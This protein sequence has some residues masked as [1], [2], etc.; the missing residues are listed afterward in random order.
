MGGR[1]AEELTQDDIASGAVQDIQTAT[2]LAR[3]MVCVWG[4]SDLGP[5]ALGHNEEPVFLGRDYVQRPNYSEATAV[6]IDEEVKRI[7]EVGLTKARTTLTDY[8][9]A[10]DRIANELLDRESLEGYEIYQL[11]EEET[12]KDRM[13]DTL[14][15]KLEYEARAAEQDAAD[16]NG[17][18]AAEKADSGPSGGTPDL[19]DGLPSPAAS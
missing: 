11:I 7:V 2:E 13:P 9:S 15:R 14:K 17:D 16:Q 18:E 10:L 4:M 19:V 1:V 6:A 3:R 8:R 12:G 5:I